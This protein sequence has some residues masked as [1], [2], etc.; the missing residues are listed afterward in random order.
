MVS[1]RF[2]NRFQVQEPVVSVKTDIYPQQQKTISAQMQDGTINLISRLLRANLDPKNRF[3]IG[4][5]M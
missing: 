2:L 5:A 1:F 3:C 4:P